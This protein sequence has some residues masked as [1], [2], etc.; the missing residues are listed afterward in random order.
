METR[1]KV[2][3]KSLFW[4]WYGIYFWYR[5][6]THSLNIKFKQWL[7]YQRKRPVLSSGNTAYNITPFGSPQ[8]LSSFPALRSLLSVICGNSKT[9]TQS[10]SAFPAFPADSKMP[11]LIFLNLWALLMV[12]FQSILCKHQ[13]LTQHSLVL[14]QAVERKEKQQKKTSKMPIRSLK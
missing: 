5:L 8:F 10:Q 1:R 11:L 7:I 2:I 9:R 13:I 14:L 3:I 6:E 4:C 12:R